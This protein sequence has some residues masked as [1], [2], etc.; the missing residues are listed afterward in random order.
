LFK[1]PGSGPYKAAHSDVFAGLLT[2]FWLKLCT[3]VE[4]GKKGSMAKFLGKRQALSQVRSCDR[5]L[6]SST[7]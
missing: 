2:Y 7:K 1:Q 3:Q 5:W 4:R 6:A